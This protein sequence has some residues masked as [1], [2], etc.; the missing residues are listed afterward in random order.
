MPAPQQAGT[1]RNQACSKDTRMHK[2]HIPIYLFGS[3]CIALVIAL[4]VLTG[5]ISTGS[6][7]IRKI[8][9]VIST[10]SDTKEYDGTPLRCDEWTL[11]EGE[12]LKEH[13]LRVIVRGERTAFGKSENYAE[14]SVIDK[15][16]LD[17]TDQYDLEL[18]LGDLEITKRKI[19]ITSDSKTVIYDGSPV[20]CDR[21]HQS[22]G[23][24]RIGDHI[25][26]TDFG[27][28][29][30]PG[31]YENYFTPNIYDVD[32][33]LVTG[34][35]DITCEYGYVI[36]RNG[37]ITI[38]SGSK[39]KEYDG[40]EMSD[41]ECW[42]EAGE[43]HAGDR[44]EMHAVGKITGVG[45]R[46]NSIEAKIYNSKDEDVTDLYEVTLNPGLLIV[47]PR[48]IAIRTF[49]IERET[50]RE[51]AVKDDWEII[52]GTLAQGEEITVTTIQQTIHDVGERENTVVRV[53]IHPSGSLVDVASYYQIAY[54]YGQAVIHW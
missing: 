47:T 50:G 34:N 36:I 15:G 48:Q 23:R 44:V 14:V 52:S 30:E 9:L 8:K 2:K 22:D 5:I 38:S 28:F 24:L 35:Y 39:E 49:D 54:Y 10:G 29:T 13:T 21:A 20:K 40:V 25:E 31:R 11:I 3:L 12:P 19:T 42:V 7:Q 4:I 6:F 17:V 32:N 27:E 26:A 41:D 33:N 18:R 16:G 45:K 43:L 51:N 53:Y 46:I 1:G 37:Y